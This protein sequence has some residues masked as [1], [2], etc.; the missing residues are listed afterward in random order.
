[1]SERKY[2]EELTSNGKNFSSIIDNLVLKFE[3]NN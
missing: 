1:M 2:T 3:E